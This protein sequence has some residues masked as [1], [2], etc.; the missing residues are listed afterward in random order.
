MTLRIRFSTVA[1]AIY[2]LVAA[3][4]AGAEPPV[5]GVTDLSGATPQAIESGDIIEALAVTRGT[6]IRPNARPTLRLPIYF[7]LDSADLVPEA[8]DLLDKL[9]EALSSGDLATFRFSVEGHTDDQGTE[10]YNA[11]L[12]NRRAESVKSF[13]LAQGVQPDRLQAVGRGEMA[14]V[15]GNDD[16]DGRKRNRR[17][18][19]VN[20]GSTE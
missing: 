11:L 16:G 15:A 9:A 5:P 18:E 12:S 17:V 13:L 3:G 8:E 14:P 1:I 4:N 6:R 20:M 10:S 19:I 7:E 2:L